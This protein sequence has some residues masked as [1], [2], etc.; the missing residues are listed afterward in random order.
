MIKIDRTSTTPVY[1][2]L[3]EQLRYLIVSG[4]FQVDEALPSTRVLG[5]Q[6]DVSFHTVR[7]AYQHL[8]EEGLLSARIGSG[9]RVQAYTPPAKSDRIEQGAGIMQDTLQKLIGLGLQESEIEHLFQEQ[10]DALSGDMIGPKLV[11]AAPYLEAA[12]LCAEYLSLVLQKSV[13]PATLDGLTSHQDADY[14][15][16]RFVDLGR[17]RSSLP[18]CDT[19]GVVSYLNPGALEPIATLMPHETM[20][21]VT[22]FADAIAP[23]TAEIR[24]STGFTG[25][26]IAASIEGGSAHLAHFIKQTDLLVYTPSS[27]RRLLPYLDDQRRHIAITPVVSR[28]SLE[29][30]REALPV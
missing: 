8:E 25:Q 3:V 15:I 5:K 4:R 30:L 27:R 9:F 26:T 11:F 16:A 23:L 28:D 13:E 21:V 29:A 1:E 6:V 10:F 14:V 17:V 2:Q 24:A 19:L 22:R 7:K 20:G 18:R 12:Q